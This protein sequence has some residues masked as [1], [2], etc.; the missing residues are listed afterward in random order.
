MR[1]IF[2]EDHATFLRSKADQLRSR[3]WIASPYIGSWNHVRRL[4]GTAWIDKNIDVRV[5]TDD[6]N[7]GYVNSKTLQSFLYTGAV[8]S[9]RGLHAKI[10]ILDNSVLVTSA[11]LT[12][13]AFSKR[14]ETGVWFDDGREAESMVN[15][16][17]SWWN[18]L[19]E[20]ID[21]EAVKE[22][23]RRQPHHSEEPALEHLR[24]L[25]QLPPDPGDLFLDEFFDFGKFLKCYADFAAKYVSIQHLWK[26]SPVYLEVDSFLNYL[27]HEHPSTPSK[28]FRERKP[29]NLTEEEK[30]SR[31]RT[32]APQFSKWLLNPECIDGPTHRLEKSKIVQ[33]ILKRNITEKISK[34][35]IEQ[36]VD[37]LN[38]MGV[39][40]ARAK[41]LNN[42]SPDSIRSAWRLLI[43]ESR[44][45]QKR[46]LDCFNSLEFC[47]RSIIQ[48]LVGFYNPIKFPLWNKNSNCGLRFFGYNVARY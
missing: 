38:C 2:P 19:S 6:N 30:V 25:W 34:A 24:K 28:I 4:L 7:R 29:A 16:F 12:G 21:W 22:N 3:L 9:L 31:I 17:Q 48:E 5:I 27:Y 32:Y 41:F 1:I 8:K 33:E 13:M 43:D 37:Q 35:E 26:D 36:V 44:P 39:A 46:M 18:S 10:Y 20:D 14:Y 40:I 15:L 11:N 42:N 45:I 47:G 23:E